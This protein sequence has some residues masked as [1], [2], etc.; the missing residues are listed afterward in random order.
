M[1]VKASGL[2]LFWAW[3]HWMWLRKMWL[4]KITVLEL[5]RPVDMQSKFWHYVL[6][7]ITWLSGDVELHILS[8]Y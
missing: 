1:G 4:R 3:G 2:D 5:V 6:L 7:R 8:N